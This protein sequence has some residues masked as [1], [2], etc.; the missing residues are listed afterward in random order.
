MAHIFWLAS[1]PRSGNTWLRFLVANLLYGDIGASAE[2]ETLLPD[3]H[4]DIAADRVSTARH[5]FV[6]THWAYRQRLPLM[7]NTA[8][9]VYLVRHPFEVMVSNLNYL[10]LRLGDDFFNASPKAQ[11][12][13]QTDYVD[14]FIAHA[15][16]PEWQRQGMGT[17][18]ENVESWTG[19]PFPSRGWW[20]A[21]R[22]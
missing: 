5:L 16:A 9:A 21:T 20:Y 6:K 1:Y 7:E 18:P 13:L 2:V 19:P 11:E 10:V 4:K 14:E 3:I 15:G 8:A 22:I 12:R 17:W